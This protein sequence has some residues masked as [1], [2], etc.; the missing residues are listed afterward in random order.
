[1]AHRT[2]SEDDHHW[3]GQASVIYND[4]NWRKGAECA[5]IA[6]DLWFPNKG[7]AAHQAKA[8]CKT[9]CLVREF[10]LEYAVTNTAIQTGIW[11]GMTP[12]QIRAIRKARKIEDQL[13]LIDAESYSGEEEEDAA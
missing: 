1:M 6:P 2:P 7:E 11:G 10:C 9:Q 13:D 4:R 5:T 8:I 3:A 12:T